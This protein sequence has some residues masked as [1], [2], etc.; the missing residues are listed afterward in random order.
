M[1]LF[2]CLA[3]DARPRHKYT[4][5]DLVS[6]IVH[7]GRPAGGSYRVQIVHPGTGD[8][9]EMEDLHVKK[10]L[11]QM[12]TLA[13]C[14][15]QIW[16][17]NRRLTRDQRVGEEPMELGQQPAPPDTNARLAGQADILTGQ[18]QSAAKPNK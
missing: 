17:L 3:E 16:R 7:E 1:D 13:E 4:T 11:P 18:A 15:I 14:Y 10:I 9:Y 8:W 6:N 12:I 2:D 5:Y